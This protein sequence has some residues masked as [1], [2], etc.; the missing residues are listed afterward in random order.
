MIEIKNL[1]KCFNKQVI[2]SDLSL[3]LPSKGIVIF[4]GKSGCGKT[5]LL[6]IIALEDHKYTGTIL[7][8]NK[9]IDNISEYKK[10]YIFY[11]R[12]EDNLV[13]D[14]TIEE[15][16]R[17]FLNEAQYNIALEY[18]DKHELY[19]LL[20]NKANN[21]SSGEY[22]K[23][24]LILALS[25]RAKITILDEPVGNIDI[26]SI[27]DFYDDLK[28]MS[29]ESLI[30]YVSHND[31]DTDYLADYVLLFSNK[32]FK[33]TKKKDVFIDTKIEEHEEKF[34]IKNFF[35]MSR[36][37]NKNISKLKSFIFFTMFYIFILLFLFTIYLLSLS[38]YDFYSYEIS[39]VPTGAVYFDDKVN[40]NTDSLKKIVIKNIEEE[41]MLYKRCETL[42]IENGAPNS[43]KTYRDTINFPFNKKYTKVK[44]MGICDEI[45]IN[46]EIFV[47]GKNEVIITNY[48]ADKL[49]CNKGDIIT[50]SKIDLEIKEVILTNYDSDE[51]S[52]EFLEK[53]D[54][55]YNIIYVSYD[56][57]HELEELSCNASITTDTIVYTQNVNVYKFNENYINNNEHSKSFSFQELPLEPIGENG[58]YCSTAYYNSMF[59]KVPGFENDD[60]DLMFEYLS[61]VIGN[62]YTV[63]F[64]F[65]DYKFSKDMVLKGIITWSSVIV[66]PEDL[67][68]SIIT[69]LGIRNIDFIYNTA[70]TGYT[71]NKNIF[72]EKSYR[73]F[74]K[75]LNDRDDYTFCKKNI[76]DN[77]YDVFTKKN[78]ILK[79]TIAA[80]I[81]I[82]I[83]LGLIYYFTIYRIEYRN[84]KK[85]QTKGYSLKYYYIINYSNRIISHIIIWLVLISALICL[86]NTTI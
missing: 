68:E 11:N 47:I 13:L 37:W 74:I 75:T 64:E 51:V 15:N 62:T 45:S 78:D 56:L 46:G 73:N 1:T 6:N 8:D 41:N 54:Y 14:L 30:I 21:I 27:N 53:Y 25:R 80:E 66:I 19:Y 61:K 4:S 71:V 31:E 23:I 57:I 26:Y 60:F 40:T 85:L 67:Y 65:G 24:C 28:E 48:L 17:L 22:Q 70:L 77:Y 82:I 42:Y 36:L 10:N 81:I 72:P 86:I 33:V 58:F 5:T 52:P 16:L 29:K 63:T 2:L 69:E 55:Y 79:M 44:Y 20:S 32:T 12:Y 3:K 35:K 39:H 59:E 49:G 50:I 76:Y 84:Y 18:I 83:L 34:S 9:V 7:F 38:K 43:Y